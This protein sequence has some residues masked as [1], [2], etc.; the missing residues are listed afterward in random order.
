MQ[1]FRFHIVGL[2]HTEITKEFL[3]CAYTQKVLNFCKMMKSLGHEVYLY[4]GGDKTD[5][6][7]DEFIS[8]ISKA[9]QDKFFG[10]VD[11]KKDM[12][13]IVWDENLPYWQIMNNK[14]ILEIAVRKQKK[15]F[16]CLIGGVC[17]K[18]IA[19][20][21]GL[22][23]VEF[24]I[25]YQGFFS[26]YKVFESYAW[27]NY[28]YG[29]QVGMAPPPP[30]GQNKRYEN[31]QSFD[32]VIPNY[33]NPDDFTFS[34]KKEDYFLYVGR[35]ILRKGVHI[36]A[37]ACGALD[38]RLILAG[39]GGQMI[40]GI[41]KGDGFELSG[42]NL[43]YV[44]S[45][46]AKKRSELMSKAKAVFLLTNY[47]EPFGGT[48]IE[49]MFCGTPVITSDN[50]VFSETV[51]QGKNGFRTRTLGEVKQAM[52]EVEGLD[53]R[54]IREFAVRNFSMDKVRYMYDSYFQQL[55]T[56]WDKGWASDWEGLARYPT[57]DFYET[58]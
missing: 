52:K 43:E 19:D 6:P 49:A 41:F 36:A 3:S 11:I 2:P 7:C 45:V 35:M 30:A 46:D 21:A 8:C 18:P 47:H 53:Y 58:T 42:K 32:A 31:G 15:D 23:T 56:L 27:L 26:D 20:M 28:T 33:F 55:N 37:E 12:F 4:G 17:Q 10:S 34:D 1:K 5:A 54:A 29:L 38:K 13:P 9:Q 22:M 57:Y 39:Q 14:A 44:G 24:G 51:R 50:G 16:L 40:D 25:G 48:H